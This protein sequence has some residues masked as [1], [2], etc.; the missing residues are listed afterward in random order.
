MQGDQESGRSTRRTVLR[1]LGAAGIAG[2]AGCAGGGGGDGGSGGDE[3]SG[4]GDGGSG[5]GGSGDTTGTATSS[6]TTSFSV[7]VTTSLSGPFAVFGEAELAGAELAKE[8]LESELDVSIEILEGDTEVNPSTGLDRMKRL[9]T[10]D[11]IDFAMGGVSSSVALNIG[12]WASQNGVVYMPTG[13]HSDAITGGQCA[14]YMFR[15]T[16]SNSMLAEAIG[17]EMAEAADSWYLLYSDYTWG[18]TAQQAVTELLEG[19]GNTVVGRSAV[20]FPHDDYSPY[21]NEARASD[22][23][24]IG[25]LIAGL[26]M[27]KALNSIIDRGVDDR[28]LAMHQHEDI[29]YWGLPKDTA[30]ALDLAGQVW[31]PASPG[32]DEF[33]QRVADNYD[34]DPYVRHFLGYLSLDQMV[35]AAVRAGSSDA[36]AMRDALEGHEVTSPAKEI[37]GGGEMYWRAC[38]HQLVQPAYSVAARPVEEMTDS[39]YKQWFDVENEFAGDDV[40]RSCDATGCQ[41]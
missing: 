36:D 15:P 37:K 4:S 34:T 24:G 18:Q 1:G 16:C 22:A 33:K 25:V 38:D 41:L 3:S 5:D 17:S 2:L 13:A 27:R 14:E 31:G 21:V 32:G 11:G 26:D 9:V 39:P 28:T 23:D 35:R 40:V 12:S 10:E 29:V 20:P 7:G 19:Q 6:G 30:G 8:D